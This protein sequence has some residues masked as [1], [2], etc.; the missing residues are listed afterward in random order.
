MTTKLDWQTGEPKCEDLYLVAVKVGD[1]AGYYAYSY[2]EKTGWRDTLP[3]NIIAFYPAMQFI[4]KANVEWPTPEVD[5]PDS[6]LAA[7][8]A[9]PEQFI[10][11]IDK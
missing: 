3:Q 1:N 4:S 7:S 10:D 8:F 6:E 9:G 5:M 2:W 11:C